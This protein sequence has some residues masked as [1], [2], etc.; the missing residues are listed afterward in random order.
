MTWDVNIVMISNKKYVIGALI[1]AAALYAAS[2][3]SRW[4]LGSVKNEVDLFDRSTNFVDRIVSVQNGPHVS[5][6]RT[7]SIDL[8]HVIAPNLAAG[9]VRSNV[10][11]KVVTCCCITGGV[12]SV[13][14]LYLRMP[15]LFVCGSLVFAASR[16]TWR[17]LFHVNTRQPVQPHA[18]HVRIMSGYHLSP[19]DVS[20][21]LRETLDNG[22]TGFP[23]SV[24]MLVE[25]PVLALKRMLSPFCEGRTPTQNLLRFIFGYTRLYFEQASMVVNQEEDDVLHNR[26]AG[27]YNDWVRAGRPR[28][29]E[30]GKPTESPVHHH[31]AISGNFASNTATHMVSIPFRNYV[32]ACDMFSR[33]GNLTSI[34][35]A[36]G[37][38]HNFTGLTEKRDKSY[39]SMEIACLEEYLLATRYC[40]HDVIYPSFQ[41]D[42]TPAVTL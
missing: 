4:I 40:R 7:G 6:S 29:I 42:Q 8:V 26:L 5:A 25:L 17:A 19:L 36:V 3:I 39:E 32:T 38:L 41:Q 28:V 21:D 24:M 10:V 23:S 12:T 18:P 1:T 15:K 31:I 20:V 11:K 37:S 33:L 2:K 9:V 27:G 35:Y 34:R 16:F 30:D 14:S 13:V 22:A